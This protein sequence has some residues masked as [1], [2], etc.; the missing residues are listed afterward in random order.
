MRAQDCGFANEVDPLR[1][2]MINFAEEV[3]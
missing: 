1:G 3:K 2:R